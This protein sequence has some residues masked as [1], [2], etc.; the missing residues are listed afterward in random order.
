M[1]M[2]KL[3]KIT[4]LYSKSVTYEALEDWELDIW[5]KNEKDD[6]ANNES[7]SLIEELGEI[8]IDTYKD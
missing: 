3:I 4:Q 5:L 2:L 1:P 7:K 8:Y 6:Y